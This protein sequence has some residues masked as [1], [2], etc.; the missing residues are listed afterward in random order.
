M[1]TAATSRPI[2]PPT[3]SRSHATNAVPTAIACRR[4]Q[5]R[6]SRRASW[7]AHP[8][9]LRHCPCSLIEGASEPRHRLI[10]GRR[11]R[12]ARRQFVVAARDFVHASSAMPVPLSALSVA[13]VHRRDASCSALILTRW[14]GLITMVEFHRRLLHGLTREARISP[15]WWPALILSRALFRAARAGRNLDAVLEARARASADRPCLEEIAHPLDEAS[16]TPAHCRAANDCRCRAARTRR[17][18]FRRPAPGLATAG[19]PG[20]RANGGPASAPSPAAT[21]RARRS[22]TTHAAA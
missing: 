15:G 21:G 9:S 12:L 6:S 5:S 10:S 20:R 7:F 14:L 11:R 13:P 2:R 18:G 4:R 1:T 8:V 22:A 16:A 3:I 19:W 17:P